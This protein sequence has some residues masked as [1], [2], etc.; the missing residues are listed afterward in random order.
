MVHYTDRGSD[1]TDGDSCGHGGEGTVFG[2]T[3]AAPRCGYRASVSECD[4][5]DGARHADP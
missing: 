2:A 4:S 5:L 3:A 1:R